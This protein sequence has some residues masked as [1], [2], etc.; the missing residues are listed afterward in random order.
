MSKV[1]IKPQ[2]KLIGYTMSNGKKRY[3]VHI[4]NYDIE[5]TLVSIS[6]DRR[7]PNNTRVFSYLRYQCDEIMELHDRLHY[8]AWLKDGHQRG[9]KSIPY[10]DPRGES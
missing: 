1:Y 10:A 7:K 6:G 3:E 8:Q 9:F 4:T 2:Y 5:N